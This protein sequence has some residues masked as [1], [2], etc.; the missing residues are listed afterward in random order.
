MKAKLKPSDF[1]T[2]S[3]S[4]KGVK[5][6]L[7]NPATKQDSGEWLHV[8][9]F[10][11]DPFQ[12]A[13]AN[14]QRRNLEILQIPEGEEREAAREAEEIDLVAVLVTGWSFDE[15]FTPEALREFLRESPAVKADVDS[16]ASNRANFLAKPLGN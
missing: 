1:F 8:I 14:R 10:D 11:S 6:P 5:M 4:N 2:R 15:P 3:Q 13:L 9:G 12:K 16:W 7:K